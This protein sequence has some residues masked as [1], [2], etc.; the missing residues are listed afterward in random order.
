MPGIVSLGEGLNHRP[1]S[2]FS[3]NNNNNN[4]YYYYYFNPGLKMPGGGVKN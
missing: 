4:Y 1:L 3:Y 2:V